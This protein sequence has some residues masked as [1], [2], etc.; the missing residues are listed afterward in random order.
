MAYTAGE[1]ARAT[2]LNVA[3]ISRA[4][5]SGKISALKSESGAWKIEP[6]ELHRV[7]PPLAMQGLQQD[8]LQENATQMQGQK[9]RPD[10]NLQAE[11]AVLR[12]RISAQERL[13]EDRAGQIDDLRGRLD[14]EAEERR[15]LTM[16]LAAPKE[17]SPPAKRGWWP[18][19]RS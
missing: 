7:F 16:M 6:A 2:G 5:K 1:A 3:T 8:A 15:K 14:Q 11:I 17:A 18:W 13:L 4:I 10:N 12:E 19:S 9:E